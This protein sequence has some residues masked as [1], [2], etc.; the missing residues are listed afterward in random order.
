M[1][2]SLISRLLGVILYLNPLYGKF[3]TH[4]TKALL[5]I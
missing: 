1:K 4:D 3:D 2:I 5:A